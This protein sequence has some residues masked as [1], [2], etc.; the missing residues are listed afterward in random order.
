MASNRKDQA[1]E[2]STPIP[3]LEQG[4]QFVASKWSE[5]SLTSYVQEAGYSVF[6]LFGSARLGLKHGSTR[7]ASFQNNEFQTLLSVKFGAIYKS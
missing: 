4:G 6:Q 3:G 1:L 5:Q 7:M 2:C